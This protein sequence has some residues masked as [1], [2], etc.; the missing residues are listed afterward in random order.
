MTLGLALKAAGKTS[1]ANAALRRA[2][3]LYP[4]LPTA[5]RMLEQEVIL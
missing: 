5:R 3:E 4:W 2:L 1:E